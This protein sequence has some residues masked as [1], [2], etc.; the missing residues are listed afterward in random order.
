MTETLK[1]E[2]L[3]KSIGDFEKAW[4]DWNNLPD[5]LN[6]AVDGLKWK[7]PPLYA[8]V[9]S[10]R[11]D[12][13]VELKKV[14]DKFV[15][16]GEGIAAPYLFIQY[17]ADWQAVSGTVRGAE[18]AQ[19]NP[20]I[21]LDGHWTGAAKDRYSAS[22]TSQQ[23]AMVTAAELCDKVHDQLISLARSGH[24]LYTEI[25]KAIAGYYGKIVELIVD[26]IEVVGALEAAGVIGQMAGQA[27]T[28]MADI[29]TAAVGNLQ[30]Q[31]I[32]ANE[33]KN[34]RNNPRGMPENTWPSSV[35]NTFEDPKLWELVVK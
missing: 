19:S 3:D 27:F 9:T 20:S 1:K 26:I 5:K 17:A 13:Q 15:E 7:A 18:N 24:A 11:D 22:R 35:S 6:D 4:D 25:V 10:K 16:I 30:E 32:A 21:S 14:M 8:L 31:G 28:A 33:L 2:D 12:A 23:Q 34:L 29:F